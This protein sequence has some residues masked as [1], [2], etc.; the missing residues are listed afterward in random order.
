MLT[1]Y[2]T[3]GGD[4]WQTAFNAVVSIIGTSAWDGL[5]TMVEG[6]AVL[7]IMYSFSSKKD[8]VIFLKW[9]ALLTFITTVLLIPKRDIQIIDITN[10]AGVYQVDN[11]PAGLAM[12]AS[13]TTTIGHGFAQLFDAMLAR[14]DAVSYSKT[15]MLFGSNLIERAQDITTQ[16]PIL[17]EVLP[18]YMETCVM[19]DIMIAGKYS[20]Q[21]LMNSN[22]PLRLITQRPS[23]I[24]GIY[25]PNSSGGGVQFVT[26]KEAA[27]QVIIPR[28]NVDVSSV[29][30]TWKFYVNRWFGK[31]SNP[32]TLMTSLISDSYQYF[33]N[34]GKSAA[35]IVKQNVINSAMRQGIKTF[36]GRS[37][38][39]A[40]MIN[41]ATETAAN[42]QRLSWASNMKMGA[43]WMPLMQ[44][45]LMLILVLSFPIIIVMAIVNHS[46]YGIKSIFNYIKAFVYFQTWPLMFAIINFACTYYLKSDG[47]TDVV[48][49]NTD[50]IAQ[51][52]S[53]MM[54]VAGGLCMSIPVLSYYLT[55]GTVDV[56]SQVAGSMSSSTA[57]V[58]SQQASTTADGNWSFNNMQMNNV[59][60]NKHDTNSVMRTGQYSSQQANGSMVTQTADGGM[61]YDTQGAM[62]KLASHVGI[63]KQASS[64]F[65]AQAREAHS[66][67]ENSLS[68]WSDNV[69]AGWN[70]LKQLSNNLGSSSSVT[71][72]ADKSEVVNLNK[73]VNM[74]NDAVMSYM[75]ATGVDRNEAIQSLESQS[76]RVSA[77]A[78]VGVKALGSGASVG[79]S[80]DDLDSRS[81][82]RGT[83]MQDSSRKSDASQYARQYKQGKDLLESYKTNH[84]GSHTKNEAVSLID[85]MTSNLSKAQQQYNQYTENQSR[86][87]ELSRVASYTENMSSDQ[88]QNLDQ[89]FASYVMRHAGAQ[90]NEILTDTASPVIAAR[91]QE[92]QQ[93]FVREQLLPQIL[94]NNEKNTG[95]TS[96]GL[97]VINNDTGVN[98]HETQDSN[99]SSLNKSAD[100]LVPKS[101]E[102]NSDVMSISDDVAT[103]KQNFTRQIQGERREIASNY[104]VNRDDHDLITVQS[105]DEIAAASSG[106]TLKGT[107]Q[108]AS[109]KMDDYQER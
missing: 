109:K 39:S 72:G 29:G 61:V 58:V 76:G 52:H 21:E 5:L 37:N 73:G 102:V 78:S 95:M 79:Y 20:L 32:N 6:L 19:G 12:I 35:D 103:K 68:G 9:G 57:G 26:C 84:A 94:E 23:Q 27:V 41:L 1:T 47:I 97:P 7:G 77:D 30:P 96:S 43:Y 65:L 45:V 100:G 54:M 105:K 28:L 17:A 55:K 89:Q 83:G 11:V 87:H 14:P 44:S 63:S 80:A 15:G 49:S 40:N 31:K 85:Q 56:V 98:I 88:Q 108:E 4:M 69:S 59:N 25:S 70:N 38:D 2:T 24:R 50:L 18:K 62:S 22:D 64:A 86:A 75:K 71:D 106:Q 107:L 74:M 60:A 48:L 8:P 101:G 104:N 3:S 91:R 92:L 13:M 53:D 66:R 90:A 16:D 46:V 42:K 93:D 36:A 82:S 51:R 33:Y 81:H 99:T 67:A 34:S 10:P